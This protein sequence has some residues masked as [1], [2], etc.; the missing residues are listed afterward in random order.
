MLIEQGAK[1]FGFEEKFHFFFLMYILYHFL[2]FLS[3]VLTLNLPIW[4]SSTD[5][6]IAAVSAFILVSNIL[7][8]KC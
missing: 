6:T 1:I 5:M 4:R 3:S 2:N 7:T 8:I